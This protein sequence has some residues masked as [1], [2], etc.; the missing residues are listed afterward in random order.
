LHYGCRVRTWLSRTSFTVLMIGLSC[1]AA[2]QTPRPIR[3]KARTFVPPA[4]VQA[5]AGGRRS[6]PRA[7]ARSA[8]PS[9]VV[10]Q[11][12]IVQFTTA[13]TPSDLSDLRRAGAIPLRYVPDHAIAVS[14]DPAFDPAA[15]PRARWVGGLAAADRLSAHT[16]ADVARERPLY[17]LTIVEFQS[18]LTDVQVAARLAEAGTAAVPR[19]ALPPYIALIATDRAAIE[20]LANDPAVAW[21]YPATSDLIAGAAGLCQGLAA[22]EG[23]V[24]E[25]ATMGDGWDGPGRGTADLGYFLLAPTTDIAPSLAAGEV[26]RALSEWSRHV[27]VRWSH[28][29]TAFE[30]RSLT[31]LWAETEHGDGFAFPPEVLAHAFY[32]APLTP[33][34]LAGDVHFNDSFEWGAGDAS[35][36]DIFTVML[37]ESG[38]SLG[39]MHSSDPNAVMYPIYHGIME[40]LTGTDIASVSQLYES[41]MPGLPVG[42]TAA[43]IG[44]GV[45][46]GVTAHNG[47]ITI[48]ASGRDVWDVSDQ[49]RYVFQPLEGDGD[50]VARVDALIGVHRWSKAGVMIRASTAPGAQ[51]AFMIVSSEKGLAFQ[52][53]RTT[54]GLT[55]GSGSVPGTAPRWVWLSR[56]GDRFWAYAATDGGSWQLIGS[57]A[58]AMGRSVLAGLALTSHDEAAVASAVFS[59]V[60]VTRPLAWS[61]RDIGAV[62]QPGSLVVTPTELRIEGAGADIWNNADAFHYT[63][64][65]LSGD[66]EIVA[67]VTS[68]EYTARWAKAGVMI[69]GSLD[70]GSPHAFML[71]S[72]GKGYAFQRR[73]SAGGVSTSTS[74]GTGTAPQ[75]LRVR[76]RGHT[77][78]ASRSHDGVTWITVGSDTIVMDQD[79]LVGLAVSSHTLAVTSLAVFDNVTIR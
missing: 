22:P 50:I 60:S 52:R 17:P 77:L 29:P 3:L 65:P 54:D 45:A 49:L 2:A 14:A 40:G 34:P 37:H 31:V 72:A 36:Y 16:A 20:R 69:R 43:P 18:D 39:L 51:H 25:Y 13:V 66:G 41:A 75:W 76:R 78:I 21:M 23:I 68:V 53:R 56:R 1:A 42:W 35:R 8:Q 24:A 46:G 38:H 7:A 61:N 67:R 9:D 4:N 30:A 44:E 71:A 12:L 6:A 79:V 74:G 63:W 5:L 32:Q 33:E 57:D 28:S 70:P 59:H 11:H 26:A 47:T 10:R 27:A 62:G 73:V 55:T 19:A 64:R 15:L 58:I 48:E